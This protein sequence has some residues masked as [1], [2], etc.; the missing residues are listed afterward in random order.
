MRSDR[1][2]RG[3]VGCGTGSIQR[4]L[5]GRAAVN[6]EVHSA[7]GNAA[8]GGRL[9]GGSQRD[10]SS[11]SLGIHAGSYDGCRRRQRCRAKYSN[12]ANPCISLVRDIEVAGGI[13][14]D[15]VRIGKLRHSGRTAVAAVAGIAV[16]YDC[17]DDARTC[18]YLADGA[19]H[20]CEVQVSSRIERDAQWIDLSV[21]RQAAVAAVSVAIAVSSYHGEDSR[22]FGYFADSANIESTHIQVAGCVE[23]EGS[24]LCEARAGGQTAAAENP[25]PPLPAKLVIMPVLAVTTRTS[26]L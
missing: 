19:G 14:D 11:R 23:R 24:G 10:G 3:G 9:D 5:S 26:L 8:A 22:R 18:G 12:L 25:K 21:R 6:A 2:R 17:R 4:R 20:T 1:E 16:A 13:E 15:P 7:G